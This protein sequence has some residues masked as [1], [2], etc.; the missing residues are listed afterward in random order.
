MPRSTPNRAIF[1]ARLQGDAIGFFFDAARALRQ[2]RVFRGLL[3]APT[4][5]ELRDRGGNFTRETG[6]TNHDC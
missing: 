3:P 4:I 1:A 2:P 6:L 5:K